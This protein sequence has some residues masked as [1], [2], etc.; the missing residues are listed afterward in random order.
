MVSAAYFCQEEEVEPDVTGLITRRID[1]LWATSPLC[2]SFPDEECRP[3]LL[4]S[5]V[6]CL[7]ENAQGMR[8]A[9]HNI[10][11]PALALKAFKD[12]PETV[13]ATRV[14]GICDMIRR[15]TVMDVADS[16]SVKLPDVAHTRAFAEFALA[17]FVDCTQRFI[18]RGQG[19]SGHLL[20]YTRALLDLQ[21][22]GY[23]QI[24]AAALEGYETYV[25]RIRQGPLDGDA[26]RAEH[27][28]ALSVPTQESYWQQKSGDWALGHVCKYPYG[29]YGLMKLADDETLKDRC[30]TVAFRIF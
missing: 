10:I 6:S 11:L 5:I 2:A 8:Q 23:Q 16:P 4:E 25:R 30:E 20:T 13:T 18:G 29:F 21:D 27:K 22:L 3:D 9:G 14:A 24:I 17:E 7:V 28:Q 15:F 19:W 12:L 26:E 1:D